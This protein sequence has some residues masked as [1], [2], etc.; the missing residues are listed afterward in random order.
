MDTMQDTGDS[1]MN[2]AEIMQEMAKGGYRV[3]KALIAPE[4]PTI[5]DIEKALIAG[6]DRRTATHGPAGGCDDTQTNP[7]ATL[8]EAEE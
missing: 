7:T 4:S 6:H 2:L 5:D 3:H 1:I 8:L